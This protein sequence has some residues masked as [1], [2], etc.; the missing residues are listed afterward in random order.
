MSIEQWP[1][2][3]ACHRHDEFVQLTDE[4]I[5]RC[6]RHGIEMRKAS[7]AARHKD[8]YG[9]APDDAKAIRVQALG[10]LCERA[11]CRYFGWDVELSI[12]VF[13][14]ADL[15]GDI[16]VRLIGAEHY[17][18]R[19]YPNDDPLWRV[20]GVVIPK[21]CERKPYR[22]PGWIDACEA[23][24]RPEWSI[25]PC[26]RPPMIAV[27]QEHLRPLSELRGFLRVEGLEIAA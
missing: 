1:V 9:Y 11:V 8:H 27:P 21:G 4:E 7:L 22:L 6:A 3:R 15:P 18:L 20:V 23:L 10:A 14:V 16:Q 26:G 17:G 13:G 5:N 24:S 12:N 25:A 19:V 2:Y